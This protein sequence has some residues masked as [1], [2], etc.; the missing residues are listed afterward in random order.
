MTD[1]HVLSEDNFG[2]R[3]I[4]PKRVCE[5]C[6]REAGKLEREI[7]SRPPLAEYVSRHAPLFNPRQRPEAEGRLD[8]G[9]KIRAK[10]TPQG[11]IIKQRLPRLVGQQGGREVWEV[12]EGTEE[13][14][15]ERRR[16]RGQDVEVIGRPVGQ[17]EHMQLRYGIGA[18]TLMEWPRFGAK[19][20]L[21]VASLALDVQWLESRGAK[22]LQLL[23]LRGVGP[24]HDSSIKAGL[25]P[26]E[27]PPDKDPWRKF[28]PGEHLLGMRNADESDGAVVWMVLFGALVYEMLLED[29]ECPEDEPTWLLAPRGE[30]PRRTSFEEMHAGLMARTSTGAD[31]S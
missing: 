2:G 13:E 9:A 31:V 6:N 11:A 7:A 24:P 20:A 26:A 10:W 5:E 21:A 19:V 12:A 22:N 1:E 27:A 23:F 4:A 15:K 30:P 17:R 29:A 8:D 3:L 28:R 14:F 18:R 16:R 25:F